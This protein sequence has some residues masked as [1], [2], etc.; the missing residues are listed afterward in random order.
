MIARGAVDVVVFRAGRHSYGF[1]VAHVQ[2]V[3][4]I[5]EVAPLPGAPIPIRGIVNV[6]GTVTPVVDFQRRF[7]GRWAATHVDQRLI[8]VR[9]RQRPL[10]VLADD[11][12][13]VRHIAAAALV[14]METLAPGAGIVTSVAVKEDGLIYVYDVD[15]LLAAHE[16]A[17]LELALG[18]G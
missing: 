9:S 12:D 6:H 14:D 7:E 2:R 11:V 4:P 10:A 18:N 13:G 16:E 17:A 8:A 5:V 15:A 3:L 1:P